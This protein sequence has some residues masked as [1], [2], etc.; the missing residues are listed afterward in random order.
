MDTGHYCLPID[1]DL[2]FYPLSK[3]I[4]M[5]FL[6]LVNSPSKSHPDIRY[7]ERER[8]ELISR[9]EYISNSL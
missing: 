3:Q 5:E 9:E 2:D 4:E 8:S 7:R 1:S 6:A